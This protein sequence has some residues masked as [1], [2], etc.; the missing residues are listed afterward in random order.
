[1]QTSCKLFL[2]KL[3]GIPGIPFA[4]GIPECPWI[5]F[6]NSKSQ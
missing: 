4:P 5:P 3:T 1:M 2:K 6:E